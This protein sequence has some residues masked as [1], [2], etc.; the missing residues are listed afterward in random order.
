[1]QICNYDI[2]QENYIYVFEKVEVDVQS[3]ARANPVVS[4]ASQATTSATLPLTY[5]EAAA[6]AGP[7]LTTKTPFAIFVT[8]KPKITSG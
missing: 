5:A 3:S 7:D 4:L 2:S 6:S 1:M 8:C